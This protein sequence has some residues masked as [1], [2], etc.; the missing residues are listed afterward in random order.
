MK[1]RRLLLLF[2]I[3]LSVLP[4]T[5]AVAAEAELAAPEIDVQFNVRIPMRDGIELSADIYRPKE[6]GR[7]PAI[8]TR[9]PYLKRGNHETRGRYW[10]GQGYIYLVQDVRGRGDSDGTFYP[11]V[12][13]SDDG[14]D[15]YNW[16]ARQ[17]WSTGKVGSLGGS[18]NGWT[19]LYPA[20]AGNTALA[21]MIPMV[22]P[23]D[24]DRNFPVQFGVPVTPSAAWLAG[25]DGRTNQDISA[26]DL[27]AAYEGRPLI[28][29]DLRMGRVLPAWRDWLQ[30]PIRDDYWKSIAYQDKLLSSEIPALHI[31]GWYDDVLVGTLENFENMTKRALSKDARRRHWLV[32]GP[33]G[34][35]VN[36]SRTLGTIDFGPDA[37]IDLE[38]LQRRWF[39]HW[40]RGIDN[41]FENER[42][43]RVF[44]MGRNT[45]IEEDAWPIARTKPK[46]YFL[47]SKTGA[48]SLYGDG[49]LSTKAPEAK[50]AFDTYRFDPSDPVPFITE[51]DSKQGGGPDDY[52]EVEK[53]RDVLV[54]TTPVLSVPLTVCGPIQATIY[55]SSSAADTDWTAKLLD[56][57][58]DGFAQR[59]TDGIVRARFRRGANGEHMLVPG[60]IE[61]YTI[62]LWATCTE[63]RKGHRIRLEVASSAA[64]KYA[65]NL[66]T[67]GDQSTQMSGIIAEQRIY[68]GSAQPSHLLLPI[69]SENE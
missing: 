61:K 52:T 15:T 1:R 2:R 38:T 5:T 44:V 50:S 58:P 64:G 36:A 63:F 46:K 33:W 16:V 27:R 51:L 24:P 60:E 34:H 53:R 13:E 10:A 18:Y 68:H 28:D 30:H 62:D 4:T 66:N 23:P 55:A 40:L 37:I 42:R 69:L 9:T 32:I 19:Q 35:A 65:V 67:A 26:V 29:M 21:A 43:V 14:V 3:A 49:T 45:W 8:V 59:L 20:A 57:H 56:V 17:P 12:N 39:D 48:N 6:P 11:I 41:G 22:T 31:S 47:E 25:L 7:Y 54:Y